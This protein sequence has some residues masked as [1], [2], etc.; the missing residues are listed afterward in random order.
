MDF[1]NY[2]DRSRG[3]IQ[4]AQTI[5]L[6]ENHQRFTV[7][8]ITKALLDD[9]EGA[10]MKLVEAAGG[11]TTTLQSDIQNALSK[12]PSVQGSGAGQLHLEPDTARMLDSA[13]QLAEKAGDDFVTSE[14]LLQAI[15]LAKETPSGE[16]LAK[17]G[18]TSQNLEKAI[19]V[20][21]R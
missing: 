7:E 5:A 20:R 13:S 17:A 14:R 6:R 8:H 16:I 10:A 19:V 12:I 9:K 21:V 1:E 3:F 2:T 11:N 4:A 15:S 18:I